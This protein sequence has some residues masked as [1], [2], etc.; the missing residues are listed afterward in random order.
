MGQRRIR[1]QQRQVDMA[2]SRRKNG[3]LKKKERQRRQLRMLGILKSGKLPY[4]PSVMSWLSEQ[5]DK[6]STRIVQDDVDK[7]LQSS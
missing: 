6:P 2:F 5:L 1:R 7:L 3:V 4:I